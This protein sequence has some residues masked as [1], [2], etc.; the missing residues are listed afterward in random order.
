L[1]LAHT[2]KSRAFAEYARYYMST[3]GQIYWSDTHQLAEYMD[4]YHAELDRHLPGPQGTEMISELYVPRQ[5]LPAFMTAVRADARKHHPSLIYGTSRL[6]ERDEETVLAWARQPWAC[7]V[8]NLHVE[9]SADGLAQ[10]AAH[11]RRLID[12][13]LELGGSYYL[14][15]HRWATRDQVE[16]AHPR[17]R[18]FLAAKRQHDPDDMFQSD[19]YRHHGRLLNGTSVLTNQGGEQ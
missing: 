8:F 6:I 18:E 9:H 2:D 11:F 17:F 14:T 15:Y 1:L 5:D 3:D 13:A 7:V 12:R 4:G 16:A 10:A 19:W